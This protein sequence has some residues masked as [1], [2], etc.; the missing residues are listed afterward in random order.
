MDKLFPTI[1]K[2]IKNVLNFKRTTWI[3]VL[4]AVVLTAALS[5]GLALNRAERAIDNDMEDL[6]E[7]IRELS[8]RLADEEELVKLLITTEVERLEEERN[9]ES[10]KELLEENLRQMVLLR[11][12][13]IWD[14]TVIVDIGEDATE[15][16]LKRES[17][18][19]I[20]LI[21]KDYRIIDHLTIRSIASGIRGSLPGIKNENIRITDSNSPP[22]TYPVSD[23][24]D[25]LRWVI[26]EDGN[27]VVTLNSVEAAARYSPFPIAVPSVLPANAVLDHID[28]T[29]PGGSYFAHGPRLHFHFNLE[30]D[31]KTRDQTNIYRGDAYISLGQ[32]NLGGSGS[33]FRDSY[34]NLPRSS[35]PDESGMVFE[36]IPF[37][38]SGTEAILS[39]YS[40]PVLLGQ[41][42]PPDDYIIY[43]SISWYKDGIDYG[44]NVHAPGGTITL[45]DMVAMA[46]SVG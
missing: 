35:L 43:A 34:N 40:M 31:E 24:T 32:L 4:S 7:T 39:A 3:I 13:M 33:M 22:L 16:T 38:I 44:L 46:E 18:A 27:E 36:S 19:Q 12:P 28:V 2:K 11:A 6:Q 21:T 45:D 26:A 8:Q 29:M 30:D 9:R 20:T 23:D 5:V 41:E 17:G 10:F 1:L 14:C 25:V 15:T 42:E 37:M